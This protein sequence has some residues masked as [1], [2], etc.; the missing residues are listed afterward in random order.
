M[1]MWEIEDRSGTEIVKQFYN[2]LKKG[3]TKSDALRKA[4][5]EYL[6]KADQLRS[7]PYFWSTLIIYGNDTPLYYSK[8]LII[9][10]LIV[11]AISIVIVS[12]FFHFRK[13]KYS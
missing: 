9:V 3:N 2:N 10:S 5:I 13:R 7:H 8:I 1:S 6:K 11:L 4:R 12:L